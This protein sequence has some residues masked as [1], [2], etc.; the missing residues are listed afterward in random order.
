MH[1]FQKTM[2]RRGY[3]RLDFH[4]CT[5]KQ[6]ATATLVQAEKNP[7]GEELRVLTQGNLQGYKLQQVK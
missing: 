2:N 6:S 3:S 5:Q 4:S 7:F 1:C